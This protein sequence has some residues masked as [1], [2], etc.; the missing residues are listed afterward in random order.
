VKQKAARRLSVG[1]DCENADALF[2]GSAF[3]E[4]INHLRRNLARFNLSAYRVEAP[5]ESFNLFSLLR[6]GCL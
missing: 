4:I 5:S 6:S 2:G 1:V 3:L